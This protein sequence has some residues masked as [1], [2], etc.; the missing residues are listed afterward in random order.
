MLSSLAAAAG[1]VENNFGGDIEKHAL[2]FLECQNCKS[3]IKSNRRLANGPPGSRSLYLEAGES[4]SLTQ[5]DKFLSGGIISTLISI[6]LAN[7]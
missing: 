3:K 4:G 6:K 5:Y 2:V 1:G 7:Y